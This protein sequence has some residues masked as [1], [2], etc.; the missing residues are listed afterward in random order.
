MPPAYVPPFSWGAGDEL[1]EYRLDGFLDAAQAAMRRRDIE[2]TNGMRQLFR[3]AFEQ[4]QR[5]R[6]GDKGRP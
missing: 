6:S 4:S 3:R 1:V 2:L 5:E